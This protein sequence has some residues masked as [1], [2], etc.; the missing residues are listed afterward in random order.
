ML[1]P[2]PGF[3]D[4]SYEDG[5]EG[6]AGQYFSSCLS[7]ISDH[8]H[9]IQGRITACFRSGTDLPVSKRAQRIN[10]MTLEL[11]HTS[12]DTGDCRPSQHH[13]D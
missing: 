2:D 10:P 4:S 12:T 6:M 3:V 1:Y 5:E 11:Q 13:R 9:V 8:C 7:K